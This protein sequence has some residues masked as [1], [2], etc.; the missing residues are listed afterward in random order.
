[1]ILLVTFGEYF[2]ARYFIAK[3]AK[4][5]YVQKTSD[6]T[7]DYEGGSSVLINQN[8]KPDLQ[9]FFEG[10]NLSVFSVLISPIFEGFC[11]GKT[12]FNLCKKY[13]KE[14]KII[15]RVE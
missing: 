6:P 12:P 1:M 7:D 10:I 2:S 15:E 8:I 5:L 11:C 14:N 4:E 3:I 9:Q 13:R